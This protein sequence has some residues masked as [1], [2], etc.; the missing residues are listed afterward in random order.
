MSDQENISIYNAPILFTYLTNV[1][2]VL[3]EDDAIV[4][5]FKLL[6][7]SFVDKSLVKLQVDNKSRPKL[8]F[9]RI[10]IV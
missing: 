2:F 6:L 3:P 5:D 10:K 9:G 1:P 7:E 4:S 8:G